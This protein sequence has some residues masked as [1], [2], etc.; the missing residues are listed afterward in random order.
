MAETSCDCSCGEK[1][2]LTINST[3]LDVDTYLESCLMSLCMFLTLAESK[4]IPE[5]TEGCFLSLSRITSRGPASSLVEQAGDQHLT[6]RTLARADLMVEV[7][8]RGLCTCLSRLG[9]RLGLTKMT[10][11]SGEHLDDDSPGSDCCL[12]F[13]SSF[14][15][16]VPSSG[17]EDIFASWIQD[18]LALFGIFAAVEFQW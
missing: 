12:L 13:C 4:F 7:V 15:N 14:S 1:M 11:D 17:H 6:L 10:S 16:I 2:I 3:F 9:A 5:S 8:A 18:M